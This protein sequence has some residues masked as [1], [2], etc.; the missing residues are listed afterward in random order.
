MPP[1][2]LDA[3]TVTINP[4]NAYYQRGVTIECRAGLACQVEVAADGS[5]IYLQTG[6]VPGV[7]T[8]E[9]AWALNGP[10]PDRASNIFKR[11]AARDAADSA[12]DYLQGRLG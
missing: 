6:G 9:L 3:G 11:D 4:G 8:H 1:G 7:L 5:A 12:F 10:E 2:S